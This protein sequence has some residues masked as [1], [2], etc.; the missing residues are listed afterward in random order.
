MKPDPHQHLDRV[1]DAL[2]PYFR[3][4]PTPYSFAFNATAGDYTP[5]MG[6]MDL[7]SELENLFAITRC[8]RAWKM[9]TGRDEPDMIHRITQTSTTD[10]WQVTDFE[11]NRWVFDL[12][13]HA[14][15][16]DR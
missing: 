15:P 2:F 8:Y 16:L 9:Q 6:D 12:R 7:V 5:S 13:V 11:G 4:S 1:V 3:D 10:V 14:T